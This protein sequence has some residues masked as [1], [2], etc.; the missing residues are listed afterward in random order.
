MTAKSTAIAIVILL[1]L[2]AGAMWFRDFLAVDKCLD[3]GG[4]WDEETHSCEAG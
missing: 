1:L 3:R 2:V 4:R